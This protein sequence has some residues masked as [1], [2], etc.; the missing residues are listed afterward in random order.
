M[1]YMEFSDGESFFSNINNVDNLCRK[2]KENMK[3]LSSD[4]LNDIMLGLQDNI[5]IIES[6]IL[7]YG[8]TICECLDCI[9]S[10]Y[11]ESSGVVADYYKSIRSLSDTLSVI[12]IE[13]NNHN[14]HQMDKYCRILALLVENIKKNTENFKINIILMGVS[15][16]NDLPQKVNKMQMEVSEIEENLKKIDSSIFKAGLAES[17]KNREAE[18]DSPKKHWLI[19]LFVFVVMIP[20]MLTIIEYFFPFDLERMVISISVRTPVIIA[21]FWLAWFSSKKYNYLSNIQDDYRYKY[22][23]AMAYQ[24]YSYEVMKLTDHEKLSALLL[25]SLI[26]NI[27]QNPLDHVKSEPHTPWAE[28]IAPIIEKMKSK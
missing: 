11:D 19:S 23:L 2:I 3:D 12:E 14:V 25:G 7:S 18:L 5:K 13:I 20:I 26:E 4:E 8:N 9:R 28:T 1:F 27:S 15:L 6:I 16:I 24:G 10:Q 21:L 17:F 22:A